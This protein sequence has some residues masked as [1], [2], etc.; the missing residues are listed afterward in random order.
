M[1][2]QYVN[3]CNNMGTCGCREVAVMGYT[4]DDKANM[5]L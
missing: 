2:D 3:Q 5:K 1:Q 4:V